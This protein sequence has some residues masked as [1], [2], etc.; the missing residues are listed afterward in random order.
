MIIRFQL[1]YNINMRILFFLLLMGGGSF[2]SEAADKLFAPQLVKNLKDIAYNIHI[3]D[4]Y[5][6]VYMYSNFWVNQGSGYN[7]WELLRAT[8]RSSIQQFIQ[9][10]LGLKIINSLY[11]GIINNVINFFDVSRLMAD[12]AA[13]NLKD[14]KV[15]LKKC[16]SVFIENWLWDQWNIDE[17]FQDINAIQNQFNNDDHIFIYYSVISND[18]DVLNDIYQKNQLVKNLLE[19]KHFCIFFPLLQIKNDG[20]YPELLLYKVTYPSRPNYPIVQNNFIKNHTQP[21]VFCNRPILTQIYRS[22]PVKTLNFKDFLG[23]SLDKTNIK[24]AM[25]EEFKTLDLCVQWIIILYFFMKNS[26][27]NQLFIQESSQ[28]IYWLLMKYYSG[29]QYQLWI[30]QKKAEESQK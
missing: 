6:M 30:K 15:F 28:K 22:I 21:H 10:L 14:R 27:N 8:S 1:E 4:S 25:I 5:Q 9:G 12:D 7:L 29:H 16:F 18:I 20:Q 26:D 2:C 17:F 13:K 11:Q 24:K 19:F 3:K 23:L